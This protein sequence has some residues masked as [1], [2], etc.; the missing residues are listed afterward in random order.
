MPKISL[1]NEY[2][3]RTFLQRSIC[4]RMADRGSEHLR[5]RLEHR[6]VVRLLRLLGRNISDCHQERRRRIV[7]GLGK[8]SIDLKLLL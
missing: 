3:Y 4:L 8:D 5:S 6:R 2:V 1:K 7:V